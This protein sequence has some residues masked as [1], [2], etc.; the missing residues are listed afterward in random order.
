MEAVNGPTGPRRA[1]PRP[2][3]GMDRHCGSS[4]S[5]AL[6]SCSAEQSKQTV[7][8]SRRLKIEAVRALALRPMMHKLGEAPSNTCSD[9]GRRCS[10]SSITSTSRAHG[11]ASDASDGKCA[12]GE[13]NATAGRRASAARSIPSQSGESPANATRTVR[14]WNVSGEATPKYPSPIDE[15]GMSRW[16]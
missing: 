4:P 11:S 16:G 15:N 12:H 14:N 13:T 3:A 7:C 5:R 1:H 10:S 9:L 8:V 2:S 6:Q